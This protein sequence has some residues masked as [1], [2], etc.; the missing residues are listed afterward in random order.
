MSE[1][2]SLEQQSEKYFA[3]QFDMQLPPFDSDLSH[4]SFYLLHKIASGPL[5]PRR[6][7]FQGETVH[8]EVPFERP[9]YEEAESVSHPRE[10]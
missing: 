8:S 10:A 4:G 5:T 9:A 1:Q 3:R 2:E 7:A 6:F